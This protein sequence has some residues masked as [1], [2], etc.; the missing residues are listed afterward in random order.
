MRK[1]L[2]FIVVFV[3]VCPALTYAQVL[4]KPEKNF[5]YLWK[6]FDSNY[7]IFGP[8]KVD[9]KALYKIY[10]PKVTAQTTDDE[11]FEIMSHMLGLLNDNHVR[12]M[13]ENPPRVFMAGILNEI[14]K[15]KNFKD[16]NE[17]R[18]FLSQRPVDQKYI[19]S[20]L[21]ERMDGVFSFGWVAQDIGYFHF[22]GFGNIPEST[23]VIDEIIDTFKEAKAIIVD[24]RKNSGGDDRVGKLIADRFADRKRL[25][26]IT[27]T[28]NGPAYDDFTPPKYWYVEPD[29]LRQ[30]TKPVVLLINR[31]S[32]SAAENF[33]LAMRVLP[34]VTLVGDLTSGVFADVYGDELP[35]GWRFAVSYKLFVDYNGFC[36]EGIGVPP[37][38]RILNTKEDEQQGND[39]VLEFA[40]ELLDSGSLKPQDESGS[41]KN[42]R[43]SL[44][45]SLKADITKRGIA[46][47]VTDFR[48][49]KAGNSDTYYIDAEEMDALGDE[50]AEAGKTDEALEVFR[51]NAEEYPDM[52][53]VLR[54]LGRTQALFG[55]K[56]AGSV[57]YDKAAA[58][59]PRSYPWEIDAGYTMQLEQAF[60]AKNADS[61]KAKFYDLK[62]KYPDFARG[63]E[64]SLNRLG[65]ELLRIKSTH[66]AIEIF[67]INV[68]A[69]PDSWNVYD[70]LGEAYMESGNKKLA[71]KNYEKSVE[72]NSKNS[73]GKEKLKQLKER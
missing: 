14:L 16:M 71:I 68:E 18:Q 4:S 20:E 33:A 63:A 50:L 61:L 65:Y 73:N 7:A 21:R 22:K 24:V 47:A 15:D 42:I 35:N 45:K 57:L 31:L 70:S 25:Y 38:L 11:L 36:W 23:A 67:K 28:R 17:A 58:L 29:G 48:K 5:E 55:D 13:S 51:L 32:I 49:A 27:Y 56:D 9:W 52:W 46:A 72:L 34:H 19:K 59:N 69:F 66:E 3:F 39:R 53:W 60:F 62:E 2:V 43:E 54:K 26:M 8:K 41:L 12:L 37:D 64:A 1:Y 6:A 44:A 10:R 40:V 30:F